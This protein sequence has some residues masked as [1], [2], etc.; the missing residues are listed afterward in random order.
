[1][2]RLQPQPW[3]AAPETVKLM[4]V[5]GEARFVGGV[6]RNALLGMPVSDIDIATPHRPEKV[7]ALLQAAGIKA[8]PTGI[9]HGTIT[10]VVKGKVFEVTTLR[11]DVAT[12]GRHA[13]VAFTTDWEKDAE[14]RD[15]TMNALYADAEGAVY[16]SV[17]G[18]ADLQAGLVRFVGDPD[19]KSVV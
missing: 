5:L 14:R 8:V 12:D 3:M 16:D 18:I 9:A 15:F 7:T 2:T 19:R 4:T 11:R 13:V 17:G 1:M 10:A 6:V